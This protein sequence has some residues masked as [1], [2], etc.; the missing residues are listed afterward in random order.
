MALDHCKII[1]LPTT[2]DSRGNLSFIAATGRIPFEMKRVYNLY[3]VPSGTV[4]VAHGR[5]RLYQFLIAM[6]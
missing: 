1:E 5:K 3:D 4:R 2:L 6:C